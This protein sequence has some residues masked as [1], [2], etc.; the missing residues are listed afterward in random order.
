VKNRH[1]YFSWEFNRRSIEFYHKYLT[2]EKRLMYGA[3][4]ET[5]IGGFLTFRP[6]SPLYRTTRATVNRS[7]VI[8][9]F[10]GGDRTV[11]P[12]LPY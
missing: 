3:R 4:A 11:Q 8:L 6:F 9:L 7:S 1:S 10:F 5:K 12:R 2:K